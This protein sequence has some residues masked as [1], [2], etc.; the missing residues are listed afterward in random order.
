MIFEN[1]QSYGVTVSHDST[2]RKDPKTGQ[3]KPDY[4][5]RAWVDH[6]ANPTWKSGAPT[7][8]GSDF[9]VTD[10]SGLFQRRYLA[11]DGQS[12]PVSG[13][14]AV[15]HI[16][17][18]D[19]DVDSN[20]DGSRDRN[21]D[22]IE[23]DQTQGKSITILKGDADEDGKAD[24]YDF[25]G[26]KDVNF[27]P[28]TLSLSS[29]IGYVADASSI[30]IRFNFDGAAHSETASTTGLFRLWTVDANADRTA[31]STFI[32]SGVSYSA[33]QLGLSPGGQRTFYLEA[34]N[35]TRR[36]KYFDPIKV[37]VSVNGYWQGNLTDLVHVRGIES[38]GDAFLQSN[39]VSA[40][41]AKAKV[42]YEFL[43]EDLQAVEGDNVKFE[44]LDA[45]GAS[46][47]I[48]RSSAIKDGL[49]YAELNLPSHKTG[50]VFKVRVKYKEVTVQ[51]GTIEIQ[52]GA[53][54]SVEWAVYLDG[55][56]V[57]SQLQTPPPRDANTIVKL[58][59]TLK[60][61]YGNLVA[62]DTPVTWFDFDAFQEDA[63]VVENEIGSEIG[64]TKNGKSSLSVTADKLPP[65]LSLMLRADQ[66]E[67]TN[68]L[69]GSELSIAVTFDRYIMY[70]DAGL[71]T[72]I[73]TATVT[74]ALGRPAPDGTPISF[75]DS[76]GLI[77]RADSV[78][79]NGVATATI[80][81]AGKDEI[82]VR[83]KVFVS[84]QA[85]GF[86]AKQH[87]GQFLQI[88]RFY[89]QAIGAETLTLGTKRVATDTNGPTTITQETL[90]GKIATVTTSN[91]TN[92][93]LR[94]L[95]PNL[96]Y[97]I[98]LVG[99]RDNT[100]YFANASTST[101]E[102][103]AGT[104][105]LDVLLLSQGQSDR[106]QKVR[107]V[108]EAW[109]GSIFDG[110]FIGWQEVDSY[111]STADV[112]VGQ[113]DKLSNLEYA[114][115]VASDFLYG[116]VFGSDDIDAGLAGDLTLSLIPVAGV[117]T[118][119]R[120]IAKSLWSLTPLSTR[121]FDARELTIGVLGIVAEFAPPADLAVDGVRLVNKIAK[122]ARLG[123][124]L[125]AVEPLFQGMAV[126]VWNNI[127]G[128]LFGSGVSQSQSQ[129][130]PFSVSS[131]A[132]NSASASSGLIN[133]LANIL[134]S[135]GP[136]SSEAA[137]TMIAF[138]SKVGRTDFTD[139]IRKITEVG[140]KRAATL[141]TNSFGKIGGEKVADALINAAARVNQQQLAHG[142]QSLGLAIRG[143]SGGRI[144]RAL[145]SAT[146]DEI[147]D[148][149]VSL[150]KISAGGTA[151]LR[152]CPEI[153]SVFESLY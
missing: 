53:T 147:A 110:D 133:D 21:D 41:D 35:P 65:V 22:W 96:D 84:I 150:G 119:V 20:D 39:F 83:G 59:A 135:L 8:N 98:R 77:N 15:I 62:D 148:I 107:L 24:N 100:L 139:A 49:A 115:S 93:K 23:G 127:Q 42:T 143:D 109:D 33:A 102:V 101:Y 125:L 103:A 111:Y 122:G 116:A 32:A 17:L 153:I 74:D 11:E 104:T 123:Q 18:A 27:E 94:G 92:V 142:V 2:T 105:S 30:Q 45:T 44:L 137:Q 38:K 26:V 51:A 4:D 54:K 48:S 56:N 5:Y 80:S 99:N 88:E 71:P 134:G 70:S 63:A 6:Y 89:H 9:F 68:Q 43:G 55:Q 14:S 3:D 61:Q 34:V 120:D 75:F 129:S 130:R 85:A 50:D 136:K 13:K 149:M 152:N 47:G 121:E 10:P 16:P 64:A 112:I 69:V 146:A 145:Q 7:P 138:A 73:V 72:A 113:Q 108:L 124:F 132:A 144:L 118:D 82:D 58:Q 81:V 117:Y 141:L 128:S 79:R 31:Q 95:N 91:T 37:D 60:D 12:N 1:G 106:V 76:K 52:P 19:L 25:D 29:N 86:Y 28:I 57:G 66:F 140:G 151:V 126:E 46:T 131:A 36:T 90:D 87:S 67:S 40:D 114:A 78:V 97:R